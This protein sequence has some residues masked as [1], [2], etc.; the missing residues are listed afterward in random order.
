MEQWK[1]H[2]PVFECDEL[3]Y[4]LL[5]YAPW[6]GHRNFTYDLVSYFKPGII[7]E[8]GSHYG[9]SAF[10]FAQAIKDNKIDAKLYAI[11]TWAGDDYTK[12][13]YKENDVYLIFQQTVNKYYDNQEFNMLRM[14]F[15]NGILI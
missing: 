13:D 9:C 1:F 2:N 12:N 3:N 10:T 15:D 5:R 4:D 7:V 14:T 8:L 11:D 6:S